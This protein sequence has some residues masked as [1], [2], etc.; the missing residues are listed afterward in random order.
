MSTFYVPVV[1]S[2]SIFIRLSQSLSTFNVLS[3]LDGSYKDFHVIH[4]CSIFV[5]LIDVCTKQTLFEFMPLRICSTFTFKHRP[6][7]KA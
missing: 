1:I 3:K 4:L 6:Y 7:K 2:S 5:L